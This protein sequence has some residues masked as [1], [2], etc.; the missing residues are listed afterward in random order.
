MMKNM[1]TPKIV[2]SRFLRAKVEAATGELGLSM[3]R[4]ESRRSS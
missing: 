2:E 3:A 1:M 4:D